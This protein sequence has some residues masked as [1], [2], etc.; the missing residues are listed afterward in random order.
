MAGYI[1]KAGHNVTV[2]NK[3]AKADKWIGEYKG[4]KADTPSKAAENDL[5]LS[6]EMIMI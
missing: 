1:S 3:S 6:L 4:S 5:F 2:F